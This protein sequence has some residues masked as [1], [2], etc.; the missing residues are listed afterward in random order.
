MLEG[1]RGSLQTYKVC[2]LG[3]G[4]GHQTLE[5]VTNGTQVRAEHSKVG[6]MLNLIVMKFPQRAVKVTLVLDPYTSPRIL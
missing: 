3:L 6:L 1:S 5:A 2:K 4:E